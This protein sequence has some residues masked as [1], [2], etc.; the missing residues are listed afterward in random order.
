VI[1]EMKARYK[2]ISLSR[3]CRLL[4][5]TRQAYYQHGWHR[6]FITIENEMVLKEIVLIRENHSRMGTRK[7]YELLQPFLLAHRI[8]MG[9]DAMFNLMSANNLLVKRYKRRIST[10]NSF[11]LYRKFPNLIKG[12]VPYYPNQL[13]VSDI[14]YWNINGRFLY[15]SFI[16]DAFSHKIV[17]YNLAE[18][19]ASV[20][21]VTAL[22]MALASAD[23]IKYLIHHSDRG[24]QYCSNGYV[25]LLEECHIQISMTQ[26]SDPRDNAIA[27]RLNGIIKNEYLCSY[28]VHTLEEGRE[29]LDFVVKLYNS[30]RPHMSIGNLTPE[31][32]HLG[33]V[34]TRKLWK[35]YYYSEAPPTAALLTK[36]E[37]I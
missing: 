32:V 25:N 35:N 30:E 31:K 24:L 22:K 10:T 8:K 16:T 4:G 9:R 7:L 3:I 13:W 27:E 23:E 12:F 1:F 11:H 15:I 26:S 18:N 5:M 6:E 20:E 36:T 37:V 14:T 28:N 29:V 2:G 19:L 17:G 34:A 21:T 33:K